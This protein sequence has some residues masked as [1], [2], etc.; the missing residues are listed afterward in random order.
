MGLA[1]G[2]YYL[3][4]TKAPAGY[5][6]LSDVIEV[7][8]D[9]NKDAEYTIGEVTYEI[10]NSTE[11][12]NNSGVELPSTGGQGTML[13]ITIGTMMAIAFAVLLIT[14]KKMSVYHD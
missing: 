11:V 1:E 3:K 14:Q 9:K 10:F 13:M 7:V 8:V 5:N 12:V 4:E 6:Q 2:T